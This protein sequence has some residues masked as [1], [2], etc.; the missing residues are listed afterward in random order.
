MGQPN[1]SLTYANAVTPLQQLRPHHRAIARAI[2]GGALRPGQL[3]ELFGLS[4]AQ[5]SHILG[6]P[7]FQAYLAHLENGAEEQAMNMREDIMQ[8]AVKALENLDEDLEM[9]KKVTR[10]H[11]ISFY[12]KIIDQFID[13]TKNESLTIK[14]LSA[15]GWK[16]FMHGIDFYDGNN[17]FKG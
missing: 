3:S 1:N 17:L 16:I 5:I 4:G 13:L 15:E 2:V 12:N 6:A 14:Q 10:E 9:P 11:I 8:M 7:A